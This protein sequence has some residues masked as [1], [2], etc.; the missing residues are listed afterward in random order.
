MDS[1]MQLQGTIYEKG[2]GLIAQQVMRDTEL[3]ATSKLIYS[4]ICSFAS[5]GVDGE[6]TAFPS[7]ALQCHELGISEDTYYKY[8]KPLID[9][10]Y[11]TI[12]KQRK[13]KSKFNNNLYSIVA[14]PVKSEKVVKE[15]EKTPKN[16]PYPNKSGKDSPYP[17]RPSTAEP[18]T[19]QPGTNSNNLNS[20]NL[21]NNNVLTIVNLQETEL[22]PDVS[23]FKK[24]F[25]DICNSFYAVFAVDRW[26]KKQWN[27]LIEKFVTETIEEGRHKNIPVG[28]MKGYAFKSIELMAKRNDRKKGLNNL[29]ENISDNV[30]FYDWVNS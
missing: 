5:G 25:T 17:N 27:K 23:E 28:K 18:C 16:T 26:S 7:I 4:Y 9:K 24:T 15:E 12:T 29:P 11:L 14:V 21:N 3:H 8:R 13:E 22:I 30:P 10:G 6:R 19:V 2:Y 20:N 1:V